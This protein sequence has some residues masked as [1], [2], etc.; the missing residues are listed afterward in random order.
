MYTLNIL[1]NNTI[2]ATLKRRQHLSPLP[3]LPP[4]PRHLVARPTGPPEQR[5][6]QNGRDHVCHEGVE[7]A[8]GEGAVGHG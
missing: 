4:L 7:D 6:G 3:P 5:D 8:R 1:I 2:Q